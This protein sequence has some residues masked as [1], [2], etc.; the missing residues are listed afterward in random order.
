MD[1]SSQNK[2][3]IPQNS[4]AAQILLTYS[5]S[6]QI[7]E[8]DLEAKIAVLRRDQLLDELLA[9]ES[10]K[11]IKL[12][13]KEELQKEFVKLILTVRNICNDNL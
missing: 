7:N 2:K 13:T 11:N 1:S 12:M 5:K 3:P 4:I 10:Q 6:D 8:E 9:L